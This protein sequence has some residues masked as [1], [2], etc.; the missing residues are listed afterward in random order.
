MILSNDGLA[1][2]VKQEDIRISESIWNASFP[3]VANR[4]DAVDR[5][6][7]IAPSAVLTHDANCVDDG[8]SIDETSCMVLGDQ[9]SEY[10]LQCRGSN[11]RSITFG[12]KIVRTHKRLPLCTQFMC[13]PLPNN[14]L[15]Y[16]IICIYILQ[17]ID[18]TRNNTREVV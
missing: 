7:R 14:F 9:T 12:I 1:L 3:S 8:D 13:V 16:K 15:F 2:N 18:L 6:N 11:N 10:V 4:L 5:T 17:L